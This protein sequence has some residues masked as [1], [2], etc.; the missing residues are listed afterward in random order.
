MNQD[1]NRSGLGLGLWVE[2]GHRVAVTR[3][4]NFARA[5][6]QGLGLELRKFAINFTMRFCYLSLA[7]LNYRFYPV[8]G[9]CHCKAVTQGTS[10]KSGGHTKCEGDV[11]STSDCLKQCLQTKIYIQKYRNITGF[12]YFL[13]SKEC[14]CIMGKTISSDPG[15][16]T[17]YF[18]C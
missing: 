1:T 9:N 12:T 15:A 4:P 14:Y 7:L 3:F 17:C 6:R 5:A 10:G 18:E 11:S 8:L 16:R 13:A 2:E